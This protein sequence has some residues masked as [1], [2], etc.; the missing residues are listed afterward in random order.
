MPWEEAK[1]YQHFFNDLYWRMLEGDE[2]DLAAG[3][4][5]RLSVI[6]REESEFWEKGA[7]FEEF[8]ALLRED[9]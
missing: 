1:R 3:E 2:E 7:P 4:M 9:G 5:L 6:A 8:I